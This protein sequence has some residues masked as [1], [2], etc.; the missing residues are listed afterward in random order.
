[1]KYK[2]SK[3]TNIQQEVEE[4]EFFGNQSSD[5]DYEQLETTR[6]GQT[7]T[8]LSQ[9]ESQSQQQRFHNLGYHEAYDKYKDDNLQQGFE[10]G[11]SNT[12]DH[13]Y[14]IGLVLGESIFE[15]DP[16]EKS[17]NKNQIRIHPSAAAILVRNYLEAEQV[18]DGEQGGHCKSSIDDVK[19]LEHDLNEIYIAQQRQKQATSS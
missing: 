10:D 13:A 3:T 4:D 12:I 17:A 5:D 1:M 19:K 6:T 14:N 15:G 9:F 18:K 7:P 2:G 11:F 16:D 8:S